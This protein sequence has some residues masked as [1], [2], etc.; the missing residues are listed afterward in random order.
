ML[1]NVQKSLDKIKDNIVDRFSYG[2]C[3]S[4]WQRYMFISRLKPIKL[5][6]MQTSDKMNEWKENIKLR[7]LDP[8]H[9][10]Q[11]NKNSKSYGQES[12]V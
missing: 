3:C 8:A 2:W 7:W 4:E 10:Q 5:N 11:N 9:N 6:Y 1:D 12:N